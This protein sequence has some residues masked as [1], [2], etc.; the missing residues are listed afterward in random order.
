MT[1]RIPLLAVFFAISGYGVLAW[2]HLSSLLARPHYQFIVVLPFLVLAL[3]RTRAEERQPPGNFRW[4]PLIVLLL[5]GSSL[6]LVLATWAWS[7]WIAM[8][9]GLVTSF[10][11]IWLLTGWDGLPRWMPAWLM[12]WILLP[13]PFGWDE[14]LTVALRGVTTRA[15]SSLL[16]L[17]GTLHL[18]YMNVIQ[19]PQKSLF[20]A[21]ACSGVH[22]LFV[23][24]AA[25]LFLALWFR[26]SA[27]HTILLLIATVGIV[28]VENITR[29]VVI[30]L[31]LSWRMDLSIGV[32]HTFL[33]LMLFL[34]SAVLIASTDQ[35]LVFFLPQHDP[36]AQQAHSQTGDSIAKEPPRWLQLAAATFSL[37]FACCGLVQWWTMPGS[38][39]DLTQSFKSVP[40]LKV[41]GQKGMPVKLQEFSQ[42]DY[43]LIQRVLGDP[44]GQQSQQWVYAR[45]SLMAQISIDYPYDGMHDATECYAETGWTIDQAEILN[46]TG[47][48]GSEAQAPF[49]DETVEPLAVVRMSRALEGSVL[50]VFSQLDRDGVALA[51]FK[52][53]S[54]GPRVV[55]A[56]RR[57]DSLV[58]RPPTTQKSSVRPP[59]LQ[60][61]MLARSAE[62]FTEEDVDRLLK[63]Y[64]DFR[65]QSRRQLV[66]HSVSG[67]ASQLAATRSDFVTP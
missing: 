61:Q 11:V 21:D 44:F 12:C 15:T 19:V 18:S 29:L 57:L 23:L 4:A 53:R 49:G 2:W 62:P 24:L 25:S 43:S 20:I 63:F 5:T 41:L 65:Q 54:A 45:G 3:L 34:G 46:W 17:F 42:V 55:D 27:L 7:P 28:L 13:P 10:C 1:S 6:L 39:P 16:E 33:G 60:V 66:D 48:S 36:R 14:R 67:T 38:L 47:A 35:L 59:L 52:H 50:L 8:L 22:S 64:V 40:D 30:V 31:G 9:S 26:R 51:G 32:N 56:Q 58:R 37:A